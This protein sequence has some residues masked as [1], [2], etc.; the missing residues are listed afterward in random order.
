V[1]GLGFFAGFLLHRDRKNGKVQP[2]FA[3]KKES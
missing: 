3:N 2:R 1:I